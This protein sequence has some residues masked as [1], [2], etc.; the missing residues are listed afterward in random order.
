MDTTE[1]IMMEAENLNDSQWF[2][3][4]AMAK[5]ME[6]AN[7]INQEPVKGVLL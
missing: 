7:R 4:L 2:E 6:A 5:G 1:L 3:I